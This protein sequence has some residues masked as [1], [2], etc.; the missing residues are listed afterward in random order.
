MLPAFPTPLVHQIQIVIWINQL[1]IFFCWRFVFPRW[2]CISSCWW[3]YVS[4][5]V[6]TVLNSAFVV[7]TYCVVGFFVISVCSLYHLTFL[8][9][10]IGMIL[11]WCRFI[12]L[13]L[14]GW[15]PQ[16]HTGG[17]SLPCVRQRRSG[18]SGAVTL[19]RQ[20]WCLSCLLLGKWF[21]TPSRHIDRS[22]INLTSLYVSCKPL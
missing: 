9:P 16:T 17:P 21:Y 18:R 6:A 10:A 12:F 14:F 13:P 3:T 8:Y 1:N 7:S 15:Q 2:I 11:R 19:S 20:G 22:T 5:V 4:H